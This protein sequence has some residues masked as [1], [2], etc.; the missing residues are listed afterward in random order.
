MTGAGAGPEARLLG[1]I[2]GS[3]LCGGTGPIAVAVSGGGDS[4]ACLDLLARSLPAE[5]LAAVSVDHGLRPEAAAEIRL[6][7]AASAARGIAHRVLRWSWDGRG[8]L[9]GAA[10]AARYRLIADWARATG[11]GR[12]VLA[13]TEDD[14]A[15]GFLL[16]LRRAPGVD[17]LAEMPDR[18]QRH[19]LDW[20]RPLLRASRADLRAYLAL[21]RI[22]WAEDPSNADP[23][24]DRARARRILGEL[25][26]LG[27]GTE[28]LATVARN[29]RAARRALDLQ[30]A[31]AAGRLV[32]EA[33]GDLRLAA[34]A[35]ADLPEEIRRRLLVAALAWISGASVPPRQEALDRLWAGRDAAT[36]QTLAGCLVTREGEDF[37]I[38][39]EYAAVRSLR[40]SPTE[41]WDGR[42]RLQGPHDPLSSRHVSA[43]GDG[44]DRCPSWRET[45]LPRASLA[46]SPALWQ[47]EA[48]V[49]A[50]VAGLPNGWTASPE[51]RG[52]FASFCL[53]D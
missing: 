7:A 50:P 14:V 49:A 20:H 34:A 23:R 53:R 25:A 42:W 48:L 32:V 27:V 24:F 19:D 12:A 28:A 40:S 31:E 8:N 29:L 45:G 46:A 2:A 22:D 41:L 13:H 37:R 6:V 47:G 17:G 10:R 3:G 30:T 4:M 1:L 44:V 51:G 36:P 33:Q 16:R 43:L 9:Q 18:F 38:A 39:R 52:N 11:I 35:A 26:P 5:Q 21:R 15:E